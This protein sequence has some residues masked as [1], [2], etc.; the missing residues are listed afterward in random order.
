M[1]RCDKKSV[2][3]SCPAEGDAQID[4]LVWLCAA[5]DPLQRR[6]SPSCRKYRAFG[7]ISKAAEASAIFS[8]NLQVRKPLRF[9][10]VSHVVR[11]IRGRAAY[12]GQPLHLCE[13]QIRRGLHDVEFTRN[14]NDDPIDLGIHSLRFAHA[15]DLLSQVQTQTG[16]KTRTG[17]M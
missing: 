5:G 4:R 14:E 3:T 1:W 11:I 9:Q 8:I 10:L 17:W 12:R 7:S 16:G 13:D 2:G 15:G 6:T